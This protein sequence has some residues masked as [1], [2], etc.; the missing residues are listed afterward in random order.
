MHDKA[1]ILQQAVLRYLYFFNAVNTATTKVPSLS[2][3]MM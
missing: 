1:I 2:E 3:K